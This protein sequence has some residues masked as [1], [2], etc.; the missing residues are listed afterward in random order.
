MAHKNVRRQFIDQ[1]QIEIGLL[2]E[3]SQ[4]LKELVRKNR[5]RK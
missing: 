5:L 1:R 4:L 2:S 3:L